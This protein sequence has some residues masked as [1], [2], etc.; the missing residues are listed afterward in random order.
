MPGK[1]KPTDADRQPIPF[2][3]VLRALNHPIRRRIL[4]ALV[5]ENGSAKTLAKAF[6]EPLGV[7]SYHLNEVLARECDV[8]E[9]VDVVPRRGAKERIYAL[10]DD[11]LIAAITT[12]EAGSVDSLEGGTLEWSP[13]QVDWQCWLEIR[14]AAAHFKEKVGQAVR[15]SHAR[16]Q[17]RQGSDE[18]HNIVL[19]LA[20]FGTSRRPF[21]KMGE[22][23][24][25]IS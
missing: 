4:A 21:S 1:S 5:H 2:D 3:R 12:I 6:H 15:E 24:Q 20:A 10:N 25:E 17:T 7:V 11:L 8:V 23:S 22:P 16:R 14:E 9:L 13:V 18:L 19:G